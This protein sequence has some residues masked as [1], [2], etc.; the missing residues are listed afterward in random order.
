[1]DEIS[2]R[3]YCGRIENVIEHGHYAEAVAHG[4]HILKQYPKHIV[5]YQL[6]GKAMLE[7]GQG[8]YAADMFRRVLSADPEDLIAWVGMSEVHNNRS[9]LDAAVWYL[10]RAFEVA[11]DSKALEEEL[12]QLYSRRDGVEPR[13]T[14]L[15]P[16]ALARLYLKGDLLSR[17][18]S[19]LR[20]LLAEH[21][22]RVELSVALAEALWRNEQRLEAS[23]V[24]QRI[25]DELPYCLKANLIL[26]AIWTGGGREEGQVYLRRAEALDP[27]NRMAQELFGVASPL[28]AR[29]AQV[30][31]LEYRPPTGEER[32][33]WMAEGVLPTEE[34]AALVDTAAGLEAQIEIPSW[35]EQVATD[36]EAE[37]PI[38]PGPTEPPEGAIPVPTEGIPTW[39]T[40]AGEG[41]KELVV[42]KPEAV[43]EEESPDWL[44]G[45]GL[46]PIGDEED[47][48]TPEWLAE[49][50]IEPAVEA[51]APAIPREEREE[52][53][54]EWLAELVGIEPAVEAEI[55]TIPREE[56]APEWLAELGVKAA[57]E[58]PAP[59][60]PPAEQPP[61]WLA[62][63]REQLVEKV[64]QVP[65]LEEAAPAVEEITPTELPQAM[66][67]PAPVA[68]EAP[69]PAW[70]EGDEMPSGDE[71]LAWLERL[72]EG[73]EEELLA[74]AAVEAEARTAEIMGRPRPVEPPPAEAA[75]ELVP[76]AAEGEPIPATPAPAEVPEW[77]QEL[78][79]P[80]IALS[81]AEGAAAPEIA[82]PTVKAAPAVEEITPTEPPRAMEAPAPVAEEAPLPAWLEGDE[83]PSG[84]EALA[85]LERLTE[86]KEEELLAQAAVEAEARTAEIMGRP[87][88]V[89]PPPAEAAPE[90]VPS[91]AEG[92]P[93]PAMPAPA[94]VPEWIQEL[95]PPEIALPEVGAVPEETIAPPAEEAFGWT[96]F[97]EPEAPPEAV[98]AAEEIP[99]G[100]ESPAW[101]EQLAR[102]KEEELLAQIEAETQERM[103]AP[104]AVEAVSEEAIAPPAE[105][106]FGW[107]AFGEPGVVPEAAV[108]IEEI[109]PAP[110]V[111]EEIAPPAAPEWARMEK[112]EAP[113]V[114]EM[115]TIEEVPGVVEM[116]VAEPLE[117]AIAPPEIPT[118]EAPAEPLAAERAFLKEHP[119]DYKA[120]LSLARALWQA[121][122]RGGALEAY[123][124]VIRSGKL[125]ESVIPDLEE[126]LE[127]QFDVRV[128]RT[129]GDAYMKDGR[130]QKALGTYRQ[131]LEAL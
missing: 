114:V 112:V 71:A 43:A 36:E 61:D 128:Q 64:E 79:P 24:C 56:K 37:L 88:P 65:A 66:E 117:E 73:K 98:A 59:S 70:L 92:E 7:A 53:A 82:L 21:P 46:E 50:G 9:E 62:G 129:L 118:A 22:E 47:E 78:A 101:L 31:P 10:E 27:E 13:R 121:G 33:E 32:P 60:V 76:S 102:G 119:R 51:E 109:P 97:G 91:A 108:A 74:Q 28:P 29:Q 122:E 35:L 69:L 100:D 110:Q 57:S 131:A 19:E 80:E 99:S 96:A 124:R 72:T 127:Q 75:P 126:Y 111:P 42:G 95:A 3:E 18:I 94:E 115:P 87:R 15:T 120:W 16:G 14:P 48:E 67:A 45:L 125:L 83:M 81:T 41:E 26:G 86:G 1:M 20:S 84:D 11:S 123:S 113:P 58:E 23:E 85:W 12:R 103:L 63:I 30:V 77:I 55:P 5:T 130:L 68:E 25:L 93:T 49:L 106:V 107:T 105:K 89:E 104:P 4:K 54:Q 17:A 44:A 6:L 52:K 8:E 90:L 40:G 39:L 2:L 116:E 38:P 34:G